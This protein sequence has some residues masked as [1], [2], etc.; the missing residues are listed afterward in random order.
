MPSYR[1]KQKGY[2]GG[3]IY[4]P[5]GKRRTLVVDKPF[6]KKTMPSWVEPIK[7]VSPVKADEGVKAADLKKQLDD[8]GVEYKGNASKE[9]LQELLTKAQDEQNQ[10]DVDAAVNFQEAPSLSG[11]V[12][13]L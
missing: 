13:T 8:L 4:D 11:P 10:R 7:E 6:D 9:V 2:Y 1:V 12:E 5:E 3:K